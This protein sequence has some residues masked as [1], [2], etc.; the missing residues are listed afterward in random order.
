[1]NQKSTLNKTI[2]IACISVFIL[3]GSL[4]TIAAEAASV[5]LA[6]N[7][8]NPAPEGYRVFARRGDQAYNYSLPAW[9]GTGSS[10]T[11]NNL[12][13]QTE[14]YFV[15]RAYQGYQESANSNEVRYVSPAPENSV[16]TPPDNTGS[17]TTPPYWDGA[18]PGIG[19]RLPLREAGDR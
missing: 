3:I 19:L 8:T 18:T 17:D 7:A 13:D 14:Y 10:A 5:T 16:P 1:M 12:Q 11:V 15:V 2:L 4:T 6:W 9:Q